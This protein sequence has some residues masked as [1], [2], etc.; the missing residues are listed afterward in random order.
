MSSALAYPSES[1]SSAPRRSATLSSSVLLAGACSILLFAPL[2][3]GAVETWAIFIV[4]A[5]SAALLCAWMLRAWKSRE[6]QFT[7]NPL[8]LPTLAFL[9]VVLLQ[10]LTGRSAYRHATYLHLLIYVSYGILVF[11]VTQSLRRSNQA[12]TVAR[13]IC[14]YGAAVAAFAFVQGLAPNG[15]LYWIL[16][17]QGGGH[18][19]GPY[20]NHNHY[21]GLME[22]LTPFPLVL[23]VSRF[24]RGNRKWMVAGIAALMAGTI[25]LSES[26]GGMIAFGI[27]AGVFILFVRPYRSEWKQPKALALFLAFAIGFLLW[28]GGRQL[29]HRMGTI[30]SETRQEINGGVRLTIARDCLHMWRVRPLLGSGLGTF[31]TVYPEFRTFYTSFFVNEA[32]NDYLQLL[33]ETGLAGTAIGIWFLVLTFR[34][35]RKKLVNWT[36]TVTGTMTVA[37]LLGCIG[38]LVHSFFDFN[39]QIPAN[40]ALFYVLCAIAASEPLHESQ[41]RRVRRNNFAIESLSQR[42]S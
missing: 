27:Q 13:A 36:E 35:A 34:H 33:V 26:R 23:A 38:I 31:A 7:P 40:A 3:Y 39:L 21:A 14:I 24:T 9:A 32:H 15:K 30:Q 41:R 1:E 16:S 19:Y 18:L 4:E 28:V 20:V 2:A 29:S 37:A 25:F 6:I 12:E 5:G 8:Y 11:V 10:L 42:E 17:L 22:M